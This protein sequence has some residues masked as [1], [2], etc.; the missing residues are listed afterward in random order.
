M[1]VAKSRVSLNKVGNVSDDFLGKKISRPTAT[2]ALLQTFALVRVYNVQKIISSPSLNLKVDGTSTKYQRGAIAYRASGGEEKGWSLPLGLRER[3]DHKA[4]TQVT[5]LL[6]ILEE[7]NWVASLCFPGAPVLRPYHFHALVVDT[8]SSNLGDN[9]VRGLLEKE[10]K[11][12]WEQDGKEGVFPP[13]V[14]IKCEDHLINLTSE[15]LETLFVREQPNLTIYGKHR[16]TDWVQFISQKLGRFPLRLP[17]QAFK[18]K[19]GIEKG[20]SFSRLS[21]TRFAWRDIAALNCFRHLELILLF[22]G[23]YGHSLTPKEK[24]RVVWILHPQVKEALALRA[25]FCADFTLPAM[26]AANAIKSG[27]EMKRF[28]DWKEKKGKEIQQNPSS[29]L[30]LLPSLRRTES[31]EGQAVGAIENQSGVKV[32]EIAWGSKEMREVGGEAEAEDEDEEGQ[33]QRSQEQEQEQEQEYEQEQEQTNLSLEV[34]EED[35]ILGRVGGGIERQGQD[36]Q[37]VSLPLTPTEELVRK[38]GGVIL[39][40]ASSNLPNQLE[41]VQGT[42]REVEGMFSPTKDLLKRNPGTRIGIIEAQVTL[43]SYSTKEVLEMKG[44]EIPQQVLDRLV[45]EA[46]ENQVPAIQ[47]A[48]LRE[49]EEGAEES[50][51]KR[52]RMEEKVSL[53]EIEKALGISAP[54]KGT[55][56]KERSFSCLIKMGAKFKKGDKAKELEELV[57]EE[58]RKYVEKGREGDVVIIEEPND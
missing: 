36:Q 54:S 20:C 6:E 5:V 18:K 37:Q 28:L 50:R 52:A 15:D 27:E 44:M 1:A 17:F 56:S 29:L 43:A 8:T 2:D 47:Q 30:L 4:Q 31:L 22:F 39:K 25:A 46:R 40:R 11:R 41:N 45:K 38:M 26:K 7:I 49:L 35:I 21:D 58:W 51:K 42:N 33:K 53:Q 19:M 24:R 23:T 13:L 10:R 12:A 32:E 16:V 57:L 14:T 34:G 3:A 55:W 48:K 9:G